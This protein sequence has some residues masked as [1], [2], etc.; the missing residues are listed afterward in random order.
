MIEMRSHQDNVKTALKSIEASGNALY[1]DQAAFVLGMFGPDT[2]W[3]D[4]VVKDCPR[5]AALLPEMKECSSPPLRML[6][7]GQWMDRDDDVGYL[8]DQLRK[9]NP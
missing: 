7:I 8:A 1:I 9:W 4:G 6:Q 5:I 2:Y 3:V